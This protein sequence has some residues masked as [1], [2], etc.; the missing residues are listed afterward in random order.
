MFLEASSYLEL[1]DIL[2]WFLTAISWMVYSVIA[3]TTHRVILLGPNSV[4]E[5]GITSW[6]K[7][8]IYFFLHFMGLCLITIAAVLLNFIPFLGA[9][10]IFVVICWLLP[11]FSLVF[12]GVAV[13]KGVSFKL[14]WRLTRSYQLLM[15]LVVV[16]FPILLILPLLVFELIP[17][18]YFL[19]NIFIALVIVFQ[20][21]AL[22]LTYKKITSEVYGSHWQ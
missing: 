15:F 22:S 1:P 11:R 8:E 6:S 13:D 17:Y 3:I 21:S 20:V 4:P 9:I 18:G 19:S 16:I 5:W 14:S 7:R 2:S 12:P 10:A